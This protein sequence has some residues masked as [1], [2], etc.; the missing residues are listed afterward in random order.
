MTDAIP[1][2]QPD[3]MTA[4]AGDAMDSPPPGSEPVGTDQAAPSPPSLW[5][6][7]PYMLLQ[8]GKTAHIVGVGIGAFA[9][10]P[11]SWAQDGMEWPPAQ[12]R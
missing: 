11:D 3:V 5:R 9:I 2:N 6:N 10:P 12:Q 7:R 4:P 1:G 8:S